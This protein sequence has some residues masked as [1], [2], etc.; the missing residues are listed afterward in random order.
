M[1]PR[2]IPQPNARLLARH[3][4]CQ[5]AARAAPR[6]LCV[7]PTKTK[8]RRRFPVVYRIRVCRRAI[9]TID[10]GPV[11]TRGR[12]DDRGTGDVEKEA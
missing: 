2:L 8:P 1:Q 9:T 10:G 11:A 4:V 6:R 5:T 12:E 7:T 3:T